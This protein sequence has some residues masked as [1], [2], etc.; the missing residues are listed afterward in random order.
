MAGTGQFRPTD[1]AVPSVGTVGET[2][3]AV[4]AKVEM[5]CVG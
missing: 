4:E 3:K 5:L 2:E 1:G